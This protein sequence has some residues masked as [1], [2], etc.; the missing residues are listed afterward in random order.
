MFTKNIIFKNF[1]G[2]VK[3]KK[4]NKLLN[5]N[6]EKWLKKYPLLN[7]LTDQYKYSFT[8]KKFKEIK[9]IFII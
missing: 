5:F 8:K 3:L 2:K 6:K 9:K 7:S 1:D 4:N